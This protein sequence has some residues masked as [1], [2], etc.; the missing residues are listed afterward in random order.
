MTQQ[1]KSVFS[2]ISIA[3]RPLKRSEMPSFHSSPAQ[4]RSALSILSLIHNL[5]PDP[6]LSSLA[7]PPT[8][9]LG[10]TEVKS[11]KLLGKEKVS[12]VSK[13]A[14]KNLLFPQFNVAVLKADS[15]S[16]ETLKAFKGILI[17]TVTFLTFV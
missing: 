14:V 15:I 8:S 1:S 2:Q 4:L 13:E 16:I 12:C 6:N 17:M 10:R 11:F 3:L 5:I 9:L 7:P